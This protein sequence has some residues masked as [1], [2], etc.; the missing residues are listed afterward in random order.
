MNVIMNVM[1]YI[2]GTGILATWIVFWFL[3]FVLFAPRKSIVPD[4]N[5][6]PFISFLTLL[7]FVLILLFYA[8]LLIYAPLDASL[9]PAWT[10]IG[11]MALVSGQAMALGARRAL[12]AQSNK[13]VLFSLQETIVQERSYAYIRH[14]MYSGLLLALLGSAVMFG[15]VW[16]IVFL[17]I[18]ILP[19]FWAKALIEERALRNAHPDD[20]KK[21]AAQTGMFVPR[22]S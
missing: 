5:I 1:I 7:L 9:R 18:F 6:S 14:P 16:G 17:L 12:T 21:Y 15:S 8:I 3:F 20:Y 22:V 2:H 19:I 13:N 10:V 11:F 4:K